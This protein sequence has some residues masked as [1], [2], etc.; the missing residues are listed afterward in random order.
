MKLCLSKVVGGCRLGTLTNLGRKG[1]QAME[2]PGCLLYTKMGSAPHLTHDNLQMVENVPVVA[3][4]SLPALADLHEVLA[5]YKEGAGKFIGMPES[6]LYCS[7]HDP[8]IC[9]PPGYNNNKTVSI[10]G[11]GGRMEITPSK[12]M[13]LQSVIQPDWFQCLSDGDT[14]GEEIS[15]KRAKKSVDRSLSFLDECLQLQEKSPELQ[16]SL[17]I[18]VIEGGDVLEERLRSAKE[19]AKR[20]VAGFLLDSFQGNAMTKET[21]LE[22]L[23]SV[24]A[25]LPEDKPRLIHGIGRPDEVLEFI[26]RGVDIFESSF[27]YQVTE[28]GSA[29]SFSYNYK[30]DPETAV[31]KENGKTDVGGTEDGKTKNETVHGAQEITSFEINLK[32]KRYQDDFSPLVHGCLCYCCKNHS[33][34]YVHHLLV[35]NELLAGVLLMMHNFQHYFGFFCSVRDALKEDRLDQLREIVSR[36]AP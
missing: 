36:K 23:S 6:V 25:M 1:T 28:R 5:E 34:A 20:P 22:L 16:R 8:V 7:L 12:F 29:L 13:A 30:P 21:K 9:S 18:G 32:E 35:T 14:V 19:T 24:T 26:E 27:P 33:R 4:L 3:Q 15:K 17:I 11:C 31:L 2:I 10:W